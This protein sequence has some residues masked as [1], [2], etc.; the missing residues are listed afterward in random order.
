MNLQNLQLRSLVKEN[1]TLELSLLETGVPEPGPDDVI[2]RVE[3][4]PL[5]PSDLALLLGPAVVS[6]ARVS[7][8]PARPVVTAD[9]PAGFMKMVS[10]RVG[11]SLA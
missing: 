11:Q 1:N 9:I 4:T 3:A 7:G 10:S 8:S 6:S 2:V 5:N